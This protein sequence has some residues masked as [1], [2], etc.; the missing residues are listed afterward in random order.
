MDRWSKHTA[1]LLCRHAAVG[2]AALVGLLGASERILWSAIST[3]AI[4]SLVGGKVPSQLK[5]GSGKGGVCLTEQRFGDGKQAALLRRAAF[6]NAV[7]LSKNSD[8]PK[9]G[10]VQYAP[11][12]PLEP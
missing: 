9:A 8:V 12:Y 2:L 1:V 6:V 4:S 10:S 5:P 3:C 11:N 7:G